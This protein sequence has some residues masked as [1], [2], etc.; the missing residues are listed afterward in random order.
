MKTRITIAVV[1]ALAAAGLAL[2]S[3]AAGGSVS[4]THL[5]GAK[6]GAVTATHL[7]GAQPATHLYG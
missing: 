2:A 3:G 7:Y 6:P 1:S 5:Y 4:A